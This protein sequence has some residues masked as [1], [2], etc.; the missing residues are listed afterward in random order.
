MR[1]SI[2][3]VG[4][5][6]HK[7]ELKVAVVQ[8]KA[9]PAIHSVANEERALGRW[10]RK[11]VRESGG[12]EIRMCYEAGPNGFALKRRLEGMGPVVVDVVAPTLTPRR[13]GR[14]VKTDPR[15]ALELVNLFRA[16]QLTEVAVP[17]VTAEAARDLCRLHRQIAEEILRKRHHIQKFLVR[18]GRIWHQGRNW[19]GAYWRWLRQHSWE[20]W[21][22]QICFEE[23]LAG[24]QELQERQHRLEE[25]MRHLAAED[26]W[27][28]PV[29]V[30]RC[31]H[32]VDT[33]A[34]LCLVT[35][36]FDAQRFRTPRELMAYLGLVPS[37]RQSADRERRGNI[38]KT[39]NRFARWVLGQ[40]A[41][42]YRHPVKV[43][44]SLKK[45]R[46]GQPTWAIAIADRAHRRLH[47]R[48]WALVGRGKLSQKAVTAVAREL[49][50][51]VWEAL[52]EAAV[53]STQNTQKA[54]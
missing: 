14:R 1:K 18:R 25:A 10:V 28:V 51:F 53:R 54:A 9:E 20:D 36:I 8:G 40:I 2:T 22:D 24:L 6:D 5:D 38:T 31:F 23:L 30:L 50:A 4:I 47:R 48:Y 49:A 13:P 26:R 44:V 37:V 32:G 12:S 7:L 19:T 35:E 33:V 17:E 43:G 39:G 52:T 45:R 11:L 16:G 34:G 15:D 27:S 29:G 42:Q 46:Q 3:W 21:K 41:W